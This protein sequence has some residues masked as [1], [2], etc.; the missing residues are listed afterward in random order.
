MGHR[1]VIVLAWLTELWLV[2]NW[3]RERD[4]ADLNHVVLDHVIPA[5]GLEK[6]CLRQSSEPVSNG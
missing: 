4:E 1:Q 3:L 6:T 5:I 2:P